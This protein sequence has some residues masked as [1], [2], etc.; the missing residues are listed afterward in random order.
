MGPTV[1]TLQTALANY[2][3]KN[4]L[5]YKE[6]YDDCRVKETFLLPQPTELSEWDL[7][8]LLKVCIEKKVESA[9]AILEL[10]NNWAH[11]QYQ[12]F[13]GKDEWIVASTFCSYLKETPSAEELFKAKTS[14]YTIQQ[15]SNIRIEYN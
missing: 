9:Q 5:D 10:R 7:Q 11:L 12:K 14:N 8:A 3:A 13:N 1:Q 4:I 15:L 6:T 2:V